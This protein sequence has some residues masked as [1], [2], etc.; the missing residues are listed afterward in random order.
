M[1]R[2]VTG[3]LVVA[4]EA[5]GPVDGPPVVLLHG[6]PYDPRSYDRVAPALATHGMRVVVPYLRGYGPTRFR[7]ATTPRSGEQAALG[8]DLVE[9]IEA[10]DLSRPLVA[11]YD[12]GGRAACVAAAVRPDL[13]GGL[14]TVTG[15]NVFGP[16]TD[17]PLDPAVEHLLWYQYYLHLERGR[18]MLEQN[19]RGFCRFL[20]T[21]WSP[22]W[23]FS[24][25]TFEATATSFDNPDFVEV[26]LHSYRHR[27]GLVAGDPALATLARRLET[28]PPIGVP[29]IVLHGDEDMAPLAASLDRSRFAGPW[30]RRVVGGAGHDLPR[31]APR[32]VTEAILELAGIEPMPLIGDGRR[33]P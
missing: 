31:E 27:S 12:W 32:S 1:H 29:A 19:R 33:P 24:E 20:W 9:L 2:V 30:Q 6:F 16:P 17:G 26:V 13:V 10:L 7:N 22:T 5:H 25:E 3:A 11:G 28:R 15:Y 18:L 14:V 8:N 23:S 4:F 21:L